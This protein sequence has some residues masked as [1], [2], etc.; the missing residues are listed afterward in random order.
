QIRGSHKPV[1]PAAEHNDVVINRRHRTISFPPMP[2]VSVHS[3]RN[4]RST[5]PT[6]R[7]RLQEAERPSPRRPNQ[8]RGELQ[9]T[10][11]M[12]RSDL[13]T[14]PSSAA[15]TTSPTSASRLGFLN[16]AAHNLT[17]QTGALLSRSN[18]SPART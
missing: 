2:R 10:R 6:Q 9:S 8:T 3:D 4:G 5:A 12:R 18:M 11:L 13:S 14:L 15:I 1:V 17:R 16:F 7:A